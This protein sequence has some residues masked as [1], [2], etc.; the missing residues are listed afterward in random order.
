MLPW[1]VRSSGTQTDATS[2]QAEVIINTPAS[3]AGTRSCDS[4]ACQQGAIYP[5]ADG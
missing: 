2:A 4:S 1:F 3:E 5:L